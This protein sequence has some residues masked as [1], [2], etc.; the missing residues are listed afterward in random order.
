MKDPGS[1]PGT[2]QWPLSVHD[3]KETQRE[4]YGEALPKVGEI[5]KMLKE[6]EEAKKEK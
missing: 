6:K 4:K 5:M 1:L 2:K 3:M